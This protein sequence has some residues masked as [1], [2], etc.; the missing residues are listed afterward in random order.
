MK[1][2]KK[3]AV[4]LLTAILLLHLSGCGMERTEVPEFT[5]NQA[6]FAAVAAFAQS[7]YPQHRKEGRDDLCLILY[8]SDNDSRYELKDLTNDTEPDGITDELA[9]SIEKI[10]TAGYSDLQI[11]EDYVAF[12]E[13]ETCKYGLLRTNS[14]QK[15]IRQIRSTTYDEMEIREIGSGWYELR[16]QLL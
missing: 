8:D 4:L 12:W 1:R 13:S 11:T 10:K 15:A 16:L 6:D 14:P 7:Y 2:I 9:T 3:I 5:E